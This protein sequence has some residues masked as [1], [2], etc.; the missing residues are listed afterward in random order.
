V[1]SF[2]GERVASL[3]FGPG[4]PE[5]DRRF[6]LVDESELRR[7]NRLTAREV[8]E[9]L[10]N[11]AT[12]QDGVVVVRT[13]NGSTLRSDDAGFEGALRTAVGRPVSLHED[14]SGDNHDDSDVLV[15]NM[16]SARALSK[17]YGAPRSE[18]RFRP[19]IILDGTDAPAYSE[20][21]WV[22]RR[23]HVGDVELEVTG[24][25]LRCA[26][27]TIDPDTLDV[28]PAF[29]RYIVERHEGKF[30]IYCKVITAGTVRERDAWHAA[31]G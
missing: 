15:I 24:P 3:R 26:I 28:D 31:T 22:G 18:L 13:A 17:E 29:L 25:N 8:H 23:F 2:R 6:M 27:P 1:K 11:A 7:G 5:H 19:N 9:L 12:V 4:G 30:G 21:D 20:L 14:A 10:G 16:E